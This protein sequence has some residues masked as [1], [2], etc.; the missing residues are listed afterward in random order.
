MVFGKH[1]PDCPCCKGPAAWST[2][3]PSLAPLAP[4]ASIE[5]YTLSANN[6][7]EVV[8]R[9]FIRDWFRLPSWALPT[10]SSP[11]VP[12]DDDTLIPLDAIVAGRTRSPIRVEDLRAFLRAEEQESPVA[13]RALE[14]LLTYNRFVELRFH[15]GSRPLIS[16]ETA[17][18][19]HFFHCQL[20][21]R[22]LI[23]SPCSKD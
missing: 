5:S 18:V 17:I 9:S 22:R 6:Q 16:I 7:P 1:G 14:F 10:R 13:L 4:T 20:K 23:H 11:D 8:K 21:N 12:A 19:L 15:F 2:L 3:V